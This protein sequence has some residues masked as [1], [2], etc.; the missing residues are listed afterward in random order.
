[1]K[2]EMTVSIPK[3]LGEKITKKIEETDFD[4]VSEYVIYVLEQVLSDT[5][6]DDDKKDDFSQEEEDEVR[7]RLKKLGYM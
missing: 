6:M 5:S 1:M 3:A 4:S 7:E 2:E